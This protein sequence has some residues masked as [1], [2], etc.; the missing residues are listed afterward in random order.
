MSVAY[1][2]LESGRVELILG[3]LEDVVGE[4]REQSKSTRLELMW[5]CGNVQA[6]IEC[7]ILATANGN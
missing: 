1:V 7:T 3:D 6:I 2:G 4:A 5:V